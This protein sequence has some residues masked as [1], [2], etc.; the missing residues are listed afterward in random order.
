MYKIKD[1]SLSIY[2]ANSKVGAKIK[3]LTPFYWCFPKWWT[4]G[5][6]KVSVFPDPVG[7]KETT[8]RF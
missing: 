4:I 7:A 2:S 6:E 8:L 5:N 1:T 3:A